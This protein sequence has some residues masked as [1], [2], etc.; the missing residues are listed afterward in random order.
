MKNIYY[1]FLLAFAALLAGCERHPVNPGT[2]VYPGAYIFLDAKVVKTKGNLYNNA[3][4]PVAKNTSFGV[5]GLRQDGET[6]IFE[7]YI[8]ND[9]SPFDNVAIMYLPER[10]GAFIYD[11]LALWEGG[12]HSFY[13]Y[14]ID[15]VKSTN[16]YSATQDLITEIGVRSTSKK[17]YMSYVQPDTLTKMVDVMTAKATTARCSEILL[18]FEHRLFAID[19]VVRNKPLKNPTTGWMEP[20]IPLNVIGAN[21][22]FTVMEGAELYFDEN[23]TISPSNDEFTIDHAYIKTEDNQF[24][25]ESTDSDKPRD[26]DYNLNKENADGNSFL[27]LPCQS[28]KVS[29]ELTY[30]NTWGEYATFEDDAVI[31]VNGGFKA[32]HKY[33]FILEKTKNS[34]DLIQFVPQVVETWEEKNVDHTFN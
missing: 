12:E 4:L 6:P 23:N 2:E 18:N 9:N 32:G 21:V 29:F 16:A 11:K 19:V 27:F 28:L 3:K 24:T 30:L 20:T 17:A 22:A 7:K 31:T 34:G 13:A 26:T 15:G 8:A 5:Y 1:I 14:Y 33:Q 25:I 10:E